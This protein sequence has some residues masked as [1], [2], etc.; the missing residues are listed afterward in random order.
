M[1]ICYFL[2]DG[3]HGRWLGLPHLTHSY[4]ILQ[5]ALSAFHIF[6]HM[7]LSHYAFNTFRLYIVHTC[8]LPFRI[9][10]SDTQLTYRDNQSS[11]ALSIHLT[12]LAHTYHISTFH[13]NLSLYVH[14]AQLPDPSSNVPLMVADVRTYSHAS[15][16]E[17]VDTALGT[18]SLLLSPN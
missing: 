6:F 2:R 3:T 12:C 4:R 18:S 9:T 10:Q 5:S 17:V 7:F 11:P 15:P 14:R 1:K 8:F 13:F 16:T